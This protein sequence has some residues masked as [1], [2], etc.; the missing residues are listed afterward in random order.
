MRMLA[1]RSRSIVYLIGAVALVLAL[2]SGEVPPR[3]AWAATL[4]VT[5]TADSGPGSLREAITTANASPG[6]DTITFNIPGSG[7]QTIQPLSALPTVTDP[8]IIDGSSQPG[9]VDRPLIELRGDQA[10]D[11][12][13]RSGVNGLSIL[14]GGSMLRA[15][16]FNRF[17]GI[18]LAITQG[19]GNVVE[20][21]FIGTTA[22]GAAVAG[23][24]RGGL[25]IEDSPDNRVGGLIP[26]ARNV[27]SGNTGFNVAIR[28]E[29]ASANVVQGNFVGTDREGRTALRATMDFSGG[30]LVTKAPN[31]I[32]GGQEEGARNVISGNRWI[33]VAIQGASEDGRARQLHRDGRGW[34]QGGCQHGC[35]NHG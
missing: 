1:R 3:P 11:G 20:G 31:A 17:T 27:I 15:L 26:E 19:S 22:D 32:I 8:V 10:G 13:P 35:R 6:M 7:V 23:N 28:G 12:D 5:T 33:G 4:V 14:A 21:C 29:G 2:A 18:G 25:L 9:Y 24:A 30:V 34:H 16:V